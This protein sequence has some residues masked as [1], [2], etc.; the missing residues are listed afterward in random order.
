M[1]ERNDLNVLIS[2]QLEWF[3]LAMA[4]ILLIIGILV[5]VQAVKLSKLRKRYNAMMSGTGVSN[6]EDL[7]VDLRIQLDKI[8]DEQTQQS[9]RIQSTIARMHTLKGNMGVKRYNAF[10][11]GGSELSFSL[12][13]LDDDQNGLVLTAIHSRETS[14]VYAKP[15]ANGES[16]YALS[17][18]EK[19]AIALALQK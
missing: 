8:E 13:I 4:A 2:E 18:E 14:Y 9:E 5:I 17:P 16:K 1:S 15:M 12:A 6:L 7:L 11:E 10:N 3:V 19:E